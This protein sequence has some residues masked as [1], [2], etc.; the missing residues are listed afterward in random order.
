MGQ[1]SFLLHQSV[2][3]PSYKVSS[4][5]SQ[6]ESIYSM[7][8]SDRNAGQAV[9]WL[10]GYSEFVVVGE[11]SPNTGRASTD[12]EMPGFHHP[13]GI[14]LRLAIVHCKGE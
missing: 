14:G 3:A 2:L 6:V 4:K 1:L 13:D 12:S 7:H 10:S 9:V 5:A 11:L 8:I